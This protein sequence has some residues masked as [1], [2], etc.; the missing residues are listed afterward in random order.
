M[1]VIA[2]V[3]AIV[4][5]ALRVKSAAVGNRQR[6]EEQQQAKGAHRYTPFGDLFIRYAVR[7]A[8]GIGICHRADASADFDYV[9]CNPLLES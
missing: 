7:A 3:L 9:P 5:A 4:V 6:G 1:A 8:P 2:I